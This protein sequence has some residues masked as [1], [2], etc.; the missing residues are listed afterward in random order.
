MGFLDGS[1]ERKEEPPVQSEMRT[2]TPDDGERPVSAN[3]QALQRYRYMPE[4]RH[5][6][7]SS[8]PTKRHS[9]S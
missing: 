4:R 1:F 2:Y 6:R 7:R 8:R 5:Q 3:E 9:L